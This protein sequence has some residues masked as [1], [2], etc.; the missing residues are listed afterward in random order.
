M[1]RWIWLSLVT[2]GL[3]GIYLNVRLDA[4]VLEAFRPSFLTIT[5]TVVTFSVMFSLGGFNSSAYRQFHQSVPQRLLVACLGL[6][7]FALLPI[8][9]LVLLPGEYVRVCLF[10]LPVLVIGGI[11]LLEVARSETDPVVLL[12]RLCSVQRVAGHLQFLIPRIDKRI[13]ETKALDLSKVRDTPM[14]EFDWFLSVPP[15]RDDPLTNLATLGLLAIQQRDAHAFRGVV[16]RF[17]ELLELVED[18]SI[19]GT[20]TDVYK[21]RRELRTQVYASLERVMLNLQQDKGTVSIARVAVDTMAEFVAGKAGNK[22]QT[23]DLTFS[24]LNLMWTLC[25]HCYVSGSGTEAKVLLVI[26][27]QVAQKGVDDPPIAATTDSDTKKLTASMF[28]F[29]LAGITRLIKRVGSYAVEA[30][31]T[32]LLYRCFDALGYLG[33]SAM[34]NDFENVVNECLRSLSQLGRE[35]RAKQLECFWSGCPVRPEAHAVERIDWIVS[36][37]A[38]KPTDQLQRW[39]DLFDAAYSRYYGME[40]EVKCHTDSS[41]K[42]IIDKNLSDKKHTESFMM[43]AGSRE[44]DYS[45]FTF[46]KDLEL[47][48]GKGIMMQGPVVPISFVSESPS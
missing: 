22:K 40:L 18:V 10:V 37:L 45:D 8:I 43:H 17:L 30:D 27:R 4:S 13:V 9:F 29:G 35:V 16:N 19:V 12:E 24:A 39:I 14:H 28:H 36:W 15:E 6:L 23:D 21:I 31:D 11:L 33:C 20:T 34:K 5:F 32:E 42:F 46:L 41:G 3:L 26:A 7:F 48:G 47:H 2:V 38:K 44:V 25:K 1:R